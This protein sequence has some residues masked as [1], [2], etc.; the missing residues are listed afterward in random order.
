VVCDLLLEQESL[1]EALRIAVD[2]E[3]GP[4]RRQRPAHQ[5]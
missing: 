3:D 1:L 4:E 2:H 5:R